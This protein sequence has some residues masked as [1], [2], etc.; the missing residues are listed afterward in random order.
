MKACLSS[1]VGFVSR[2]TTK[3]SPEERTATWSVH[4]SENIDDSENYDE[5]ENDDEDNDDDN[6]K[7]YFKPRSPGHWLKGLAHCDD[8]DWSS[9]VKKSIQIEFDDLCQKLDLKLIGNLSKTTQRI[10]SV[11]GGWGYP[12]FR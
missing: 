6:L 4:D 2:Q 11:K 10:F 9:P 3:L 5:S 7:Q 12:L 8:G 1:E